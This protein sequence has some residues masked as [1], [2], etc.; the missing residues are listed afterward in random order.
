MES[1][2]YFQNLYLWSTALHWT[3]WMAA[4]TKWHREISDSSYDRDGSRWYKSVSNRKF[5]YETVEI[6]ID[7]SIFADQSVA[8]SSA[9]WTT[10]RPAGCITNYYGFVH[11]MRGWYFID[12]SC[13]Q[14]KISGKG[15]SRTSSI[16]QETNPTPQTRTRVI[17]VT[18]NFEKH[19]RRQLVNAL[20]SGSCLIW[21]F[22]VITTDSKD[23]Q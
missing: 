21:Y 2:C 9:P 15:K 14:T 13:A 3:M 16:P 17:I 7:I 11:T 22:L 8:W 6:R 10:T 1:P 12:T 4:K 23:N 18:F 20:M 19:W 5:F